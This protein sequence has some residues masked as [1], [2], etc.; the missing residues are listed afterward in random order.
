[1]STFLTTSLSVLSTVGQL[2]PFQEVVR[3][4][5]VI[6]EPITNKLLISAAPSFFPEV[7]RLIDELDAQ[8]PQVVVQ[9]LVAEVDLSN[10][11]EFGVEIGLQNPVLFRRSVGPTTINTSITGNQAGF[12]FNN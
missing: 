5:I 10:E 11:E 12:N 4:V 3:D 2:T 9:V 8:P 1:L 6:P 7:M